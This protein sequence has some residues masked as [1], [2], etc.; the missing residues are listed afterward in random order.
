MIERGQVLV[1]GKNKDGN[2]RP[3]DV[4][5]LDDESFRRFVVSV[6]TDSG[7]VLKIH[8]DESNAPPLSERD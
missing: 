4:L 8:K 3:I 5:D 2:R 1:M 7:L 6:L